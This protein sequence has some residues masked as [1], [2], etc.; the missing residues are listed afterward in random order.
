MGWGLGTPSGPITWEKV[1]L[2]QAS[3]GWPESLSYFVL[4]SLCPGASAPLFS[5]SEPWESLWPVGHAKVFAV[6]GKPCSAQNFCQISR[7]LVT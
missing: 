4:T 2:S 7:A 6:Q 3:S 5:V 1:D